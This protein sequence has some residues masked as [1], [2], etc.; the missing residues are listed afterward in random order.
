M[1][2]SR[3]AVAVL[4]AGAAAL[5]AGCTAPVLSVRHSLP[6]AVPMPAGTQ[7][8]HI[9]TFTVTP[10]DRQAA[11]AAMT[12]ALQT[13]LSRHWAIDGDAR[14]RAHTVGVTG[15]IAIAT[16]EK[17][18]TRRL[19]Q[20]DEATGAWR[21]HEVP[22]FVRTASA[23]VTFR[24]NRPGDAHPLGAVDVARAYDSTA[25][26]RVRGALGLARPDDPE[27]LPPA[28][29][30]VRELIEACADAFAGMIA[31]NTVEAEVKTRGTLSGKANDGLKAAEAGDLDNAVQH[32]ALAVA[33]NPDD[34]TLWFNLAAA[35]EAAGHLEKALGHYETVLERTDG[36]DAD[37]AL[38]AQRVR[39]ILKRRGKM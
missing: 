3:S 25:D 23:H 30:V 4:V 36:R 5:V 7:V 13:H 12:E 32:L 16:S 28:D 2:M 27:H 33:E 31:P 21:E 15:T 35:L 9:G 29:Q 38:A 8:L 17:S 24:L 6:A 19:R 1:P 20:Y 34:V 26:P 11:A 22:T 39:R 10:P 37:A 14:A 18:G